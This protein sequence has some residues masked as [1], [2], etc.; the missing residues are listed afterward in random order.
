[1]GRLLFLP[2]LDPRI[3]G[4]DKVSDGRGYHVLLLGGQQGRCRKLPVGQRG[5]SCNNDNCLSGS[6]ETAVVAL[7]QQRRP[8]VDGG[9]A[10]I[11]S[12]SIG[13]DAS[14][15]KGAVLGVVQQGQ[16]SGVGGNG[17]VFA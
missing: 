17:S 12:S 14:I 15:D 3:F 11:G 10:L 4:D 5:Q 1:M 8:G 9:C 2:T 6:R 13:G 16:R 7:L